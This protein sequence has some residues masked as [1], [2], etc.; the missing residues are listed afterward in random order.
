[1]Q[2]VNSRCRNNW[3]HRFR[4]VIQTQRG[5]VERCE[6]CGIKVRFRIIDG[7]TDNKRYLSYHMRQALNPAHRYFEKEYGKL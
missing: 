7:K 5:I 4:I 3:L 6:I 2:F 1:M